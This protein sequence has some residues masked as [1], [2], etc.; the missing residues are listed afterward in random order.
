[1]SAA[2][3]GFALGELEEAFRD[4]IFVAIPAAAHTE[5]QIALDEE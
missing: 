5:R 2:A 3:D 1:M 4:G